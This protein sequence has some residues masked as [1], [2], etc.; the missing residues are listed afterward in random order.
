MRLPEL[1]TTNRPNRS[2]VLDPDLPQ[3]AA[4]CDIVF[5]CL[6]EAGAEVVQ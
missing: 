3:L 1:F 2:K 6:P 5:L 4:K